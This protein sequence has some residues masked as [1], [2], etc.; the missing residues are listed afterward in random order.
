MASRQRRAHQRPGDADAARHDRVLTFGL[1]AALQRTQEV[2]N[3]LLLVVLELVEVSDDGVRFGSVAGEETPAAM[4]PDRLPQ[5]RRSSVVQ[6]Q[7]PLSQ[8]PQRGGAK[9]PALRPSLSDPIG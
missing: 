1:A 5:V 2:E 6:E 3:V 8:A 7:Q 4:R 9:L